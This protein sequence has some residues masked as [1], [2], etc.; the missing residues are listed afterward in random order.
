MRPQKRGANGLK[1]G[2]NDGPEVQLAKQFRLQLLAAR[3]RRLDDGSNK[4]TWAGI[5]SKLTD[6]L[7]TFGEPSTA[8][9]S[10][11]SIRQ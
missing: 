2:V 10:L 11:R 1:K 4:I 5:K 3:G 7:K 6:V 9:S 8:S